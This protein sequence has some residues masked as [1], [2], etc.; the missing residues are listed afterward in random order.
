VIRRVLLALFAVAPG[1]LSDSV[2]ARADQDR[3]PAV[4]TRDVDVT[5]RAGQG[6]QAV[7]QRSRWSAGTRRL[8]VDTPTPGVYAI[9]DYGAHTLMMVSEPAHGV[10]DL[11]AAEAGIPGPAAPGS[12]VPG[13][14]ASAGAGFVRRGDGQV[15]GLPCTEWETSDRQGQPVV[16]C[17]TEDGVL[18]EARHGA[19]VFVQATRVAYDTLDATVFAVPPSYSHT[20]PRN[21]R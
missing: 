11:D 4:P 9:A 17:Y 13:S 6:G 5:Y 15:V 12:A 10:L 14:A 18:L 19:Q 16:A 3:P 20:S 21:S 2:P 1:A 8:R 7:V